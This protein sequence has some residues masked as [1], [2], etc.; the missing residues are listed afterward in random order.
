MSSLSFIATGEV[1][2]YRCNMYVCDW[3]VLLWCCLG[4]THVCTGWWQCSY[5][6][7]FWERHTVMWPRKMLVKPHHCKGS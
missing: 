2:S 5:M 1:H 4:M 3:W 6:Q 7:G